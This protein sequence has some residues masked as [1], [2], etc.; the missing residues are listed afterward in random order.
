MSLFSA[1]II[2]LMGGQNLEVR[3]TSIKTV[4]LSVWALLLHLALKWSK[5]SWTLFTNWHQHSNIF[6]SNLYEIQDDRNQETKQTILSWFEIMMHI[7]E[8]RIWR[9]IYGDP[10]LDNKKF[11]NTNPD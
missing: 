3:N 2:I 8:E 10:H 9:N 1:D 7:T 5:E 4:E 11:T 6:F